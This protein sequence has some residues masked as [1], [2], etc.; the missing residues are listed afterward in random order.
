M[1]NVTVPDTMCQWGKRKLIS[2]NTNQV[3]FM[4]VVMGALIT[5]A[6]SCSYMYSLGQTE[7]DKMILGGTAFGVE[8]LLAFL[9]VF[10][11][12]EWLGSLLRYLAC[13]LLPLVA[14]FSIASFMVSQQWS[15]DHQGDM[16]KVAYASSVTQNLSGHK[17]S[18]AANE[19]AVL[20]RARD[21][22]QEASKVSSS[23]QTAIYAYCANALGVSKETFV[24]LFRLVW[25]GALLI[26]VLAIEAWR[27]TKFTTKELS[28]YLKS[29]HRLNSLLVDLNRPTS[30]KLSTELSTDVPRGTIQGGGT[31][32]TEKK[33]HAG[34]GTNP[35]N[36]RFSSL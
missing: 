14:V 28:N 6:M 12:P 2:E 11:M 35:L 4:V 16:A 34:A 27:Q 36:S 26:G 19:A 20:N 21:A 1:A 33:H 3:W 22:A 15:A 7:E 32:A 18:S 5:S 8:I 17:F 23:P 10:C 31:S 30:S 29:Y 25:A 13:I 24:M 9:A